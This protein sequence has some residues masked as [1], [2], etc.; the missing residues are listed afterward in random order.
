VI[1]KADQEPSIQ[2]LVQDLVDQRKQGK[3][4]LEKLPVKSSGGKDLGLKYF[5]RSEVLC[6]EFVSNNPYRNVVLLVR[7]SLGC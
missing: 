3:T 5:Y 2:Y 1:V 4:S 7:T 6:L